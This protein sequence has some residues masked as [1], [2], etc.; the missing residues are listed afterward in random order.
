MAR[1]RGL[2][3]DDVVSAASGIADREGLDAVTLAAVATELGVRSPSL[4]AHVDGLAGLRRAMAFDAVAQLDAALADAAANGDGADALRAVAIAYRGFARSHPGLYAAMLPAP[5]DHDPA[6][7]AAFAAPVTTITAVLAS[8]GASDDD[9]VDLIR[10]FR[11]ALHGFV[12]LEAG[13][14][15]GMPH[16][17][18]R[19]FDALVDLLIA[20][21]QSRI[22]SGAAAAPSGPARPARAARRTTRARGR[23]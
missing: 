1:K 23:A 18:D 3:L 14:G 19:S 4:Y 13:D 2:R 21:V 17:V 11:S 20:G 15:F 9:A 6:L 12:A 5:T 16:D 8:L 7:Y 22:R 10:A